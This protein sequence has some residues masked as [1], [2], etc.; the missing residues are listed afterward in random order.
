M[1]DIAQK[2]RDDHGNTVGYRI[3]LILSMVKRLYMWYGHRS[4]NLNLDNGYVYRSPLAD[5]HPFNV[6]PQ[7]EHCYK[8]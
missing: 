3:N 5:R 1:D 7:K 2:N 4:H 6:G 8:V